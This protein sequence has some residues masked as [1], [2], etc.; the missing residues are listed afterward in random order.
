LEWN[1]IRIIS[2]KGKVEFW[3]NGYRVVQ[4]EMH[5]QQWLDMIKN[6][7]FKDMPDFGLSKKGRIALQDHG[8]NVWYRNIRIRELK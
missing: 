3:Q 5:N 1:S 7:K 4:F 8:D 2:N 6:S